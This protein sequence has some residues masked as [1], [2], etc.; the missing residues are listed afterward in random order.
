MK[1]R[2]LIWR[3]LRAALL[4]IAS[5]AITKAFLNFLVQDQGL[6]ISGKLHDLIMLIAIFGTLF[7]SMK[8][9]IEELDM[10]K[11][12]RKKETVHTRDSANE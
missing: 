11:T 5:A 9:V 6:L 12:N 10:L 7:V 1:Y 4:T 2:R 3:V 8:G